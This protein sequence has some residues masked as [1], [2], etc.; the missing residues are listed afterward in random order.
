[1]YGKGKG[2]SASTLPYKR[3]PASWVSLSAKEV[4]DQC[5]K[6]AKKGFVC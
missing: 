5:C 4:E 6:L 2:M 3:T 1:M